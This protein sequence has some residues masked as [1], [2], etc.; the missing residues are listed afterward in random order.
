MTALSILRRAERA[1]LAGIL[2]VLSAAFVINIA[3]R[4]LLPVYA[5]A[6][7]WVDEFGV[8]ALAWIVFLGLGLALER[9]EH[10]A[11]TILQDGLP[12][13]V[14]AAVLTIIRVVG[15]AFSLYLA[16]LGVDIALFV[17]GSG[18]ISPIL[19][20]SMFWLYAVVPVGFAL[21][22]LRYLLALLD[23]GAPR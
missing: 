23:R 1:L 22:A 14:R 8:F 18:Q 21:L 12:P 3:V 4:S 10:I 13:L 16:K 7:A 5:S 2:L 6:F 9:R 15:L 11:M 17:R 20:V 19:N